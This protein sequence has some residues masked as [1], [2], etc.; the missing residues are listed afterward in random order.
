MTTQ[1]GSGIKFPALMCV[2]LAIG[3][4]PHAARA[5]LGEPESTA[6]GDAQQLKGDIKSTP[7]AAYR[8]HEIQLP[9][10]TV[11]REYAA[12]GGNV[13]AVAWSGP[14][15][16]NLKQALGSY[17]DVYM[18]AAK[19]QRTGRRHLQIQQSG[20]VMESSGHMRAFEGRAYLPQALPVGT[21]LDEIR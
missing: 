7:H 21:A 6:T 13:F 9:S 20:F 19:A 2:A 16:P 4:A 5:A 8:L 3:L 15:I 11:L 14:T 17:F 12:P 10:G 1:S 18:S